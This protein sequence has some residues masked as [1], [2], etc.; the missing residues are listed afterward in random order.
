MI[1]R[2]RARQRLAQPITPKKFACHNSCDKSR[3]HKCRV[4]SCR[5]SK[6]TAD[7]KWGVKLKNARALRRP[8]P[9]LG[10][11]KADLYGMN[12]TGKLKNVLQESNKKQKIKSNSLRNYPTVPFQVQGYKPNIS[13]RICPF[14]NTTYREQSVIDKRERPWDAPSPNSSPINTTL[15][16]PKRRKRGN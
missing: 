2:Q 16:N 14:I 11:P 10:E 6:A 4:R 1:Q 7:P 13:P 12:W 5:S 9:L 15:F 8:S 3:S